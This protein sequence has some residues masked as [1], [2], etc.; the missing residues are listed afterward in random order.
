MSNESEEFATEPVP[1]EFRVGWIRVGLISAMVSF[2][3]PMFVAG[4]EVFLVTPNDQAVAAI[5]LRLADI[6]RG[7]QRLDR[8]AYPSELLYAD[9]HLV[10]DQGRGP[11]EYRVCRLAARLVRG[12]Y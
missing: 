9:A 3:L 4:V 2:S 12:Q 6:D 8:R 10:R 11:G 1:A 7:D 5:L